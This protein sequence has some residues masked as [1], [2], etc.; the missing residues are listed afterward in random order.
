MIED[1]VPTRGI[2][3][4]PVHGAFVHALDGVVLKSVA[5]PMDVPDI[6]TGVVSRCGRISP[7]AGAGQLDKDTRPV[8]GLDPETEKALRES[9]EK[10][11]A[12]LEDTLNNSQRRRESD[13]FDLEKRSPQYATKFGG[14]RW[15][16][17]WDGTTP[18]QSG[19]KR[20]EKEDAAV[21]RDMHE[22]IER[23]KMHDA[24]L[25]AGINLNEEN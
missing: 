1:E 9:I 11:R 7:L 21:I 3:M 22:V 25:A 15:M 20:Q 10:M 12:E 24:M 8:Q 5:C 19:N 4:C 17:D 18:P 2:Y 13:Q 23:E 16:K 6:D 14:P